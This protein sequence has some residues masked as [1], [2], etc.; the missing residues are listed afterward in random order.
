MAQPLVHRTIRYRDNDRVIEYFI[1][2]HEDEFNHFLSFQWHGMTQ[3]QVK[4][5]I[6]FRR[7]ELQYM[8]LFT[9]VNNL[10]VHKEPYLLI[11]AN[12][13]NVVCVT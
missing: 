6:H 2:F 11:Y 5:C 10:E 12:Y 1:V 9:Q 7:L 13:R 3:N 8:T 4:S